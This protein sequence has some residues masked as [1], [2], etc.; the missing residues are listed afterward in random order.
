[1][2]CRRIR[3]IADGRSSAALP[4]RDAPGQPGG[5]VLF[6]EQTDGLARVES[7]TRG[8]RTIA[9]IMLALSAAWLPA[10]AAWPREPAGSLECS[11]VPPDCTPEGCTPHPL[12]PCLVVPHCRAAAPA[13]LRGD[14]FIAWDS[15]Q[16]P[17]GR[18][19]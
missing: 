15:A 16:P 2:H 10:A 5:L 6:D 17:P 14:D 7:R 3:A 19:P 12:V 11:V 18:T 9:M 4:L 13:A 1:M 8:G